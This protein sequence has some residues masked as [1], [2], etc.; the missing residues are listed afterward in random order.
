MLGIGERQSI[1]GRQQDE[2]GVATDTLDDKQ[3][4]AGINEFGL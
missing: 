4:M 2:K 1:A 3:Q